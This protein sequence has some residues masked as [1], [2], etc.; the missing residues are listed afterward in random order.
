MVAAAFEAAAEKAEEC[1][2][3][4]Y[5]SFW[6]SDRA[7]KI[8]KDNRRGTCDQVNEYVDLGRIMARPLYRGFDAAFI[9]RFVVASLLA[10]FLQWGTIGG[11]IAVAVRFLLFEFAL[12]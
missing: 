2:P 7:G 8:S 11:A 9:T 5:T 6:V 12:T 1:I 4:D 3:V 10:L